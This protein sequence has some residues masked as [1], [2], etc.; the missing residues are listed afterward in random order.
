MKYESLEVLITVKAYPNPSQSLGESVCIAGIARDGRFVRLYPVPFRDLEDGQRFHKYQW[1][2]VSVTRPRNDQ[3]PETWRPRQ[4]SFEVI[5]KPLSTA[6]AW[7]ARR[8]VVLANVSDSVCDIQD[9]QKADRTSLGVFR[10]EEVLDFVWDKDPNPEWTPGELGKLTQQ[11]LFMTKERKLLQ[12][13]PYRFRYVFRCAKCRNKDPH[14]QMVID[15]ELAEQYRHL[16]RAHDEATVLKMIKDKW[17]GELCGPMK[18][19]YFFAGNMQKY[20]S[21]FLVLGVFWPPR[22]E[23]LGLF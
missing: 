15:W 17:L 3:R 5:S 9:R 20:P 21:N 16:R 18:D 6:D 14:E 23:Q 22:Q 11:D 7:A 10:P 8:E 2:R 4:D 13:L 1:V 12:K 19:T